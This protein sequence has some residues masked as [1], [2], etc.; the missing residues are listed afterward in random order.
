VLRIHTSHR[1]EVLLDA[2]VR[3]LSEER[4]RTSG[5]S[6]VRVV[7]PNKNI[8]TYLRLGVA[9]R[10]GIAAN[11]ETTFL[12]KFLAG[13]AERAVPEAR[14]VDAAVI[15]GHLLALLHDDD[16]LA[17]ADLA[18]VRGYL[19]AAGAERDAVDR[20]RCQLA[21]A[22]AHLFDEYAGSRA[23][24]LDL[25]QKGGR[26]GDSDLEIWQ[27]A[28]WLE[29]FGAGGRLERQGKDSGVRWLPLEA[30]WTE[31]MRG[32]PTPY[33]GGI[34]HVFGLSYIATAYHRMLAQLAH[35]SEI[36]VYTLNPCREKL[37]ELREGDELLATEAGMH[38]ALALWARPGRENLRR[39]ARVA[40]A[41][42]ETDFPAGDAT[43]LLHRLQTD[44]VNRRAPDAGEGPAELD[45]SLRVLPCPSLRRELEVVAAEIWSL[46]R[47]DPTLRACDVAVIVPEKSKDLY[48]AQLPAVFRE[49]CELAHNVADAGVAGSHRAALAIALLVELPFSTFSRKDFLPLLTHPCLM[50][51][52]PSATPEGWRALAAEL[53][54][55]R[56][57]D[58][59][60]FTPAYLSRD[61]Y[62]WDQGL[63]RLALGAVAD[64]P[65]ADS[66]SPLSFGGDSYL[67]G[68][69]VETD[70]A[71]A[72]GFGLLARSLIADA[73]FASGRTGP[74]QRPLGEWLDF[75]RGLI[76]SYLVL[77]EDDGA[78]QA[79]VARFL[80]ELDELAETGLG[81][82]PVSY[83]VAAELAKRALGALPGSRGHYLASGVTVA[84]FVPMRAIPFRAVFVLGLGQDAFPRSQGRHELDL[85][86]G[87]RLPGDVDG[88]EQDLYMFLETLL[89]AREHLTFSYVSRDE[90]T[91]DELPASPALLEL[92]AILGRSY[93]DGAELARLFCD[94]REPRPK[95]RRYD[96]ENRRRVFLPAAEAERRAKELGQ[97]VAAPVPAVASARKR[98]ATLP[99]AL[100]TP[101][102]RLLGLS[103][104]GH[105]K[106]SPPATAI[107]VSLANL[108]RFLE[109][110]LQASARFA[111]GMRE[112]DDEGVAD[113]EHEPF[114]LD[115]LLLSSLMRKTMTGAVL[116]AQGT[117]AWEDLDAAHERQALA[118]EL[119]GR[120]PAG[121]LRL[122]SAAREKEILRGWREAL[123]AVLGTGGTTCHTFRFVP[124]L[125]ANTE[126]AAGAPVVHCRAPS[127]EVTIPARADEPERL[128]AVTIVGETGLWAQGAA[129]RALCFTTRKK[130]AAYDLGK[131]D[132]GAFL[133][134]AV[135]AAAGDEPAR[136]GFASSL[137]HVA[138]GSAG[139]RE[140][141]FGPLSAADSRAY[142]RR[143]CAALVAGGR[144]SDGLPTA[145][146]PYLLPHEAVLASRRNGTR[147]SEEIR[148]LSEADDR[149]E[150]GFSSTR[151]PVPEVTERFAPPSD[152][153]AERMIEERFGL[154]FKLATEKGT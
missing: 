84:S 78:G 135:L 2:F 70:D 80:A 151:G 105:G 50:A 94:G 31:A 51:R 6:P 124:N 91:G 131:E 4:Q 58:R 139:Q 137:F 40:G 92:R 36:H 46:L 140:K 89:S 98:L 143:L 145:V 57:A 146:H 152:A 129:D 142:L 49:S 32:S 126:M 35:K 67:P 41:T 21:A 106:A 109:D 56:G 5:F 8:E 25:W 134:Y 136:P 104:L 117:P 102:A 13:L 147:V 114:D 12:R 127:F 48:L 77:E 119:A 9:E 74:R 97:A 44:I 122:A 81:Q 110:P 1:T 150:A 59:G 66:S 130:V 54:I 11:L 118:A 120:S 20:R 121:V 88:R 125:A 39:L 108:R 82:C 43:T 103:P 47:E 93:L 115:R 64:Q 72:L 27:R 33:A 144:D 71:D 100:F 34:V 107:K 7:V 63:A 132:L 18:R 62:S 113:V 53:G 83:R 128:V 60:D 138:K 69:L 55:V 85:R 30:L 133:E 123:P 14:V 111:L 45:A 90:I 76:G 65:N 28:L 23:E 112:D 99:A 37:V 68:P 16:L 15:E 86:E 29:I 75:V 116:A 38:P 3:K 96:D 61:L 17:K 149:R 42:F 153:E 87:Q 95:L 79:V 101:L 73:R 26:A 10:L 24:M 141:R 22:L 154:F 148:K 52:F 19:L